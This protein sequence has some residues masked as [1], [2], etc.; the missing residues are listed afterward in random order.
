MDGMRR[1]LPVAL[2]ALGLL[3]GCGSQTKTVTVDSAPMPGTTSTPTTASTQAKTT[4]TQTTSTPAT[5]PSSSS[6]TRSAPEPAFTEQESHAEG[7]QAAAAIVRERG[8]TPEDTSEYHPDQTLRVLV[9]TRTGATDADDQ[10]VFFFVDGRYLGTDTKEPS[11][12]VK[13]VSQSDTEVAVAY[14]MYRQ[15]DPLCCPGGGQQIV[16]FALNDGKLTALDPI[17]PARS[18][19]GLSRN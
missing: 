14:A 6:T 15:G 13:V 19:T 5:T 7:A 12:Q 2:L 16:H 3:V 17:P 8:Y 11:G 1:L 18:S 9:G 4:T 10:R